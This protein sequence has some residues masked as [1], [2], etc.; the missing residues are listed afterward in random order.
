MRAKNELE[1]LLTRDN[2][3]MNKALL[4]AEA[5]VRKCKKVR[6]CS[7]LPC[8]REEQVGDES[9][10]SCCGGGELELALPNP[11]CRSN[12]EVELG[13]YSRASLHLPE[14]S[15]SLRLLTGSPTPDE[16]HAKAVSIFD[17]EHG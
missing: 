8:Y 12:K 3:A 14:R 13:F 7:V 1:Q 15:T 9:L 5:C 11:A 10:R 2:T 17:L 16:C 4:E 6:A